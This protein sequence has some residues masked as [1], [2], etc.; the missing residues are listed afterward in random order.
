MFSLMASVGRSINDGVVWR[1]NV[2]MLSMSGVDVDEVLV[3][4]NGTRN[5]SRKKG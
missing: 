5:D 4:A 1:W 3:E 2:L